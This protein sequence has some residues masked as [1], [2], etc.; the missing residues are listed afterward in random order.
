M[1]RVE[2]AEVSCPKEQQPKPK[3]GIIDDSDGYASA[4]SSSL[5]LKGMVIIRVAKSL[6]EALAAI[7]QIGEQNFRAILVDKN[8][9]DGDGA[10]AVKVIKQT[11][12]DLS[13]IG[14]TGE[15]DSI[16][17]GADYQFFKRSGIQ[18]LLDLIDKN[19]IHK[20]V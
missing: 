20:S 19:I 2:Q 3:I 4:I 7:P 17:E 12:P 1:P 13:V 9:G 11:F 18:A 14:I 8:L 15:P 6:K 16:V 5:E 10:D